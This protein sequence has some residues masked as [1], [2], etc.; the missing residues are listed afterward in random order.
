MVPRF[1]SS[2]RGKS[3]AASASYISLVIIS[4]IA[5]GVYLAFN[6][7]AYPKM[8]YEALAVTGLVACLFMFVSRRLIF[9][10]LLVLVLAALIVIASRLKYDLMT[11]PLLA[12]DLVFY[13]GSTGT[14]NFLASNYTTYV[15]LVVVGLIAGLAC[16]FQAYRAEPFIMPRKW[17]L[18]FTAFCLVGGYFASGGEYKGLYATEKR[19]PLTVFYR[20]IDDA[21]AIVNS[22][23]FF[24]MTTAAN[25]ALPPFP[26]RIACVPGEKAPHVIVIHQESGFP[27]SYFKSIKYNRELDPYFLS[28]DSKL[29]KLR[30]ET[31]G[32]ASWLTEF[33]LLSGI[34]TY[35]FGKARSFIQALMR[36]RLTN[37]LP[38][39]FR[40]CGYKTSAFYTMP[41]NFVASGSFYKSIGFEDFFDAKAQGSKSY[42]AR[43]LF[44]YG[45]FLKYF[46]DNIANS[47]TKA[48]S[49]ILTNATHGPYTKAISPEQ[50]IKQNDPE[51]SAEMNEYL[52]RMLLAKLD[53]DAFRETLVKR[54]PDENFLI[55]RYGDHQP[56]I[57]NSLPEMVQIHDRATAD[58]AFVIQQSDKFS[59]Y[60]AVDAIGYTPPPL[61]EFDTLEVPYLSTV[62]TASAG[63]PISEDYVG[64]LVLMHHCQGLYY[65]CSDKQTVLNFHR[66]LVDAGLVNVN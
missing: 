45:N 61:P 59:T 13:L 46:D 37:A 66:R 64:R 43:D 41:F 6:E 28:F 60:Y 40:D 34:S 62:I 42:S 10:A 38:Q 58:E 33:S 20:S 29:H 1:V 32:G 9:S 50:A 19:Y 55:V 30:V 23:L 24:E 7:N 48:F 53:Y 12:Y 63:L 17:V 27:P 36:G 47:K 57:N 16:L 44:Y 2:V 3:N 56:S 21:V 25:A 26:P 52:R 65:S 39:K 8:P 31:Y 4:C 22:G 5:F 15:V 49:Y 35:S 11:A 18:A 54:Y 14:L 51:N